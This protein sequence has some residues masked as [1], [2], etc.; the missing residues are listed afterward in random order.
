MIKNFER[1]ENGGEEEV[2]SRLVFRGFDV[3]EL[4]TFSVGCWGAV[5]KGNLGDDLDRCDVEQV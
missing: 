3:F 5:K 2:L 1:V 4:Y